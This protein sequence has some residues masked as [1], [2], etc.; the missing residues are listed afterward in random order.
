MFP[1]LIA[2]S[3]YDLHLTY[4]L[5]WAEGRSRVL[6]QDSYI[7]ASGLMA[8]GKK[9]GPPSTMTSPSSYAPCRRPPTL[10]RRIPVR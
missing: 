7:D 10:R 9:K 6:G 1:L 3:R 2:R 4:A 8:S 5:V